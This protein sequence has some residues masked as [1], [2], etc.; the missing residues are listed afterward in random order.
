[1]RN[2][3]SKH[4]RIH[5]AHLVHLVSGAV[6]SDSDG[7][8]GLV[9]QRYAQLYIC[10]SIVVLWGGGCT[11]RTDSACAVRTHA[12]FWPTLLE[13]HWIWYRQDTTNLALSFRD[14]K[15]VKPAL[16]WISLCCCCCSASDHL[17]GDAL[18]SYIVLP[19]L[20]KLNT[21]TN[22]CPQSTFYMMRPGS[23]N[24]WRPFMVSR[25]TIIYD[26]I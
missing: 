13:N 1:M 11:M 10:H 7:D 22:D 25:C 8:G 26:F 16:D 5:S 18:T 2:L 12:C 17:E 4:H 20:L 3:Q 21:I 19:L 23:Q 15:E 9:W 6:L 14:A 24:F